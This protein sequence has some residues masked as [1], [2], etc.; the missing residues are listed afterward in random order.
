MSDM[1]WEHAAEARAALQA[2]VTDPD[3]GVAALSSAQ[4]MSNLLKDLLPDAPRE[5][6][7]LVAAAEADLAA[8]LREHMDQGLDPG[9]A[10]RL[11]ASSFSVATPYP[12][13][14]CMWV[15]GE[16][17]GAI[18]I[19]QPGDDHALR[20]A[21]RGFD[22]AGG[23][24]GGPA[25][26]GAAP[27]AAPGF[28]SAAAPGFGSAAAPGFGSA[29]APG[30]EAPAH[31]GTA[32]WPADA[33]DQGPGSAPNQGYPG[34]PGPGYPGPPGPGYGSA[35]SPGY[36]SAGG[37]GYPRLGFPPPPGPGY[38]QPGPPG[39]QPGPGPVFPA[40]PGYQ[41][42]KKNGFAIAALVCGIAQF[43]LWF[44]YLV[45]GLLAAIMAIVFGS[46]GLRQIRRTGEAG[47]G[48]AIAGIV[49]AAAGVAIV[50]LL[51]AIGLAVRSGAD[52]GS[53]Y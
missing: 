8:R 51:I 48:M 4:I 21:T 2:I 38:R 42:A 22:A 20:Q 25:A 12:P 15:T 49:C 17:A 52:S 23:R 44:A 24:P 53:G 50:V 10:I 43:V 27:A 19:S 14:A 16:I 41:P 40:V 5:K 46:V 37:Q 26:S 29:A 28:G 31:G 9:S 45:P 47:R 11:A 34:G 1:S 13:E 30:F 32:G 36:G 7:I 33:P 35:I 18:G 3:H 6:S 39:F